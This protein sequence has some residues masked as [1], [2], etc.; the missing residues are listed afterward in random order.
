M[1]REL[2]SQ[3]TESREACSGGTFRTGCPLRREAQS[4]E[5]ALSAQR[6]GVA[7]VLFSH[8]LPREQA[9]SLEILPAWALQL[10]P[11]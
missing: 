11:N 10:A 6:P 3:E 4:I 5:S 7:R 2:G 8:T 9:R 1:P